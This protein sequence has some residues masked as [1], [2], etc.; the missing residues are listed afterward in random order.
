[1]AHII[2]VLGGQV[3]LGKVTPV[4][5][6]RLALALA[7]A[8]AALVLLVLHPVR[9]HQPAV[10]AALVRRHQSQEHQLHAV[11]VAA[12]VVIFLSALAEQVAAVMAVLTLPV[13][14]G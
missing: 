14:L 8:V 12:A 1:V 5:L 11:A 13:L 6:V 10:M 9:G 3:P 7:L 2:L 4:A